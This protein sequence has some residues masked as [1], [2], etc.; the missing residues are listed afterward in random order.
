MLTFE[1]LEPRC[2][3]AASISFSNGLLTVTGDDNA[4]GLFVHGATPGVI[5][6]GVDANNDGDIVD[7]G[8]VVRAVDFLDV[9]TIQ[10]DAQHGDDVVLVHLDGTIPGDISILTRG[11]FDWVQVE[12]SDAGR[13][14]NIDTGGAGDCLNFVEVCDSP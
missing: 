10:I 4:N 6:A 5:V 1:Q 8:D 14:L 11:G 13:D 9:R 7:A 12:H 3:L 2:L